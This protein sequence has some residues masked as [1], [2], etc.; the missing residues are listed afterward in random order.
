MLFFLN[1]EMHD[2]GGIL[3]KHFTESLGHSC[4]QESGTSWSC[5]NV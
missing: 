2:T 4:S 1:R 3:N 5:S